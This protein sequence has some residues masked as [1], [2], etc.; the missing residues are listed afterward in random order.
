VAPRQVR[1]RSA[2]VRWTFQTVPT[3]LAGTELT[4]DGTTATMEMTTTVETTATRVPTV[5]RTM[6]T[7]VTRATMVVR[8]PIPGKVMAVARMTTLIAILVARGDYQIEY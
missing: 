2:M 7:T 6:G 3:R 4:A 1:A 8:V 5:V